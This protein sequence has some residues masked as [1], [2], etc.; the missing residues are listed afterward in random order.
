MIRICLAKKGAQNVQKLRQVFDC[1]SKYKRINCT[2]K[3]I[4]LF[5]DNKRN[6]YDFNLLSVLFLNILLL[7]FILL[8]LKML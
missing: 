5:S 7:Q 2:F 8:S 1:H 4:F 6:E 3:S